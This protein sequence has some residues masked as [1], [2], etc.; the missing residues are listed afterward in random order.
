MHYWLSTLNPKND[1]TQMAVNLRPRI[2]A[3][4]PL[5]AGNYE[6]LHDTKLKDQTDP[7]AIR[8]SLQGAFSPGGFNSL[9]K[10]KQMKKFM[11]SMTTNWGSFFKS[12]QVDGAELD[13]QIPMMD[14][15][16]A[17]LGFKILGVR[18]TCEENC[19]LVQRKPGQYAAFIYTA[20]GAVS[21]EKLDNDPMM[22]KCLFHC[23]PFNE[24]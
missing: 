3:L 22:K 16:K 20:S 19:V 7:L 4:S 21:K 15:R 24:E 23:D 5:T 17:A 13:Q 18:F 10:F 8:R 14:I 1:R 12:W 11:G 6:D 2:S 9:P